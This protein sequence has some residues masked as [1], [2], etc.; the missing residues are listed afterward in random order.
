MRFSVR[1]NND[2][3]FDEL[4][5]VAVS[6]ESAGFDQLWVSNDLFLRS[7]PA[8]LGALAAQTT[9]IGLGVA[10]MN[11]YSVHVSELAMMAATLQEI[12]GGR[13][14][15]GLGAGSEQFLGW[16]GITRPLP[17]AT[18]RSAL[19][20]LRALLGHDDV[21]TAQL[22]DW[23]SPH[24]V[25][26][27]GVSVPVPVYLGAMGPKMLEMAGRH[28][29]GALPLLYPPERYAS[30]R[31]DVLAGGAHAS[32]DFDLPACFWVSVSDDP[33]AART[34][35]AEKLAYYG[36]S[37]SG[38][39]LASAGL[40]PQDFAAA[41]S[42][43]HAGRAAAQLI[44]DRMLAL[45]VAGDAGDVLRRCEALCRLGARHLSFGPPLGPDPVAAIRL[46]GSQVLPVLSECP[47]ETA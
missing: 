27:F 10:V 31:A 11:P 1:V 29:D 9:T 28:A 20:G 47:V 3:S 15:L 16:A 12:S 37:I 7:A 42:L 17:L 18:T 34:A 30:A 39:V 32:R 35:L 22:P 36:P 8:L 38:P 46:L 21:D 24:S 14:L 25:L 6:A 26:R 33:A 40:R 19:V 23:F 5:A 43:A 13:F 45:G 44:D 41:A 4:V 2:L